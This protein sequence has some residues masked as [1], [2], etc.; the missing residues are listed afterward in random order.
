[1]KLAYKLESDVTVKCVKV[2]KD[3]PYQ[4]LSCLS[5][6]NMFAKSIATKHDNLCTFGLILYTCIY[7]QRCYI[8]PNN[9][10]ISGPSHTEITKNAL[11]CL[12]GKQWAA[13]KIVHV[14][15]VK[16]GTCLTT[17]NDVAKD[18]NVLF[19]TCSSLKLSTGNCIQVSSKFETFKETP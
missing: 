16:L 2:F 6:H 10:F 4:D 17:C 7:N 13:I 1:M 11:N 14:P 3:K 19:Q 5:L 9:L 18:N 12:L 15:Y 8:V